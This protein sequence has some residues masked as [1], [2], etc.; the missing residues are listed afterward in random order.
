MKKSMKL[1][2]IILI[3]FI[4]ITLILLVLKVNNILDLSP[5]VLTVFRVLSVSLLFVHAIRKK[6]LTT[7]I[8]VC[9]VA[10]AEFGYDVPLVAKKLQ[11]LSDVFLRLIKTI[12][13]PL[14]STW[15][16]EL[17]VMLIS[18]RLGEWVGNRFFILR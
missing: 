8:L 7:W 3:G 11:V 18:N 12:I 4:T 10:G 1:F 13:A 2:P 9:M 16:L 6:S 5:V 14:L 15:L 17:Q